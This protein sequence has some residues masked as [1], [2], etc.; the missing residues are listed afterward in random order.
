MLDR[1]C[2]GQKGAKPNPG[3]LQF[4]IDASASVPFCKRALRALYALANS[5]LSA[6]PSVSRIQNCHP[7]SF[8]SSGPTGRRHYE[9]TKPTELCFKALLS[10]GEARVRFY[11]EGFG[12]PEEDLA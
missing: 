1:G 3:V 10:E 9:S 4:R 2:F 7:L 12:R 11:R 8:R 5:N 6:P